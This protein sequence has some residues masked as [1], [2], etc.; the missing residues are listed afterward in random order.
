M[1]S[2]EFFQHVA[3]TSPEPIPLRIVRAKGLYLYGE[4]GD[5]IIDFI[6][7]ICVNNLG[8]GQPAVIQAIKDQAEAYLHPNVYGDVDMA[9]Q[10][11]Y[12]TELCEAL[13]EGFDQVYFLGSG[14]EAVDGALKLAKKSTGRFKLVSCEQS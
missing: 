10:T 14:A 2:A 8:H 6:S 5:K 3:Q 11:T 4:K 7:G 13:G 1:L 9:P 12:A